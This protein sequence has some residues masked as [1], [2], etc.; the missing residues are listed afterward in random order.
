[1]V[2]NLFIICNFFAEWFRW[3][4]ACK[5]YISNCDGISNSNQPSQQLD[6]EQ[7]QHQQQQQQQQQQAEAKAKAER[8]NRRQRADDAAVTDNKSSDDHAGSDTR[9]KITANDENNI[10]SDNSARDDA[11]SSVDVAATDNKSSDDHAG[12]DTRVKITANDDDNDR[13][14]QF[15]QR[16]IRHTTCRRKRKVNDILHASHYHSKSTAFSDCGKLDTTR[17]PLKRV[18]GG[19]MPN[20]RQHEP[21]AYQTRFVKEKAELEQQRRP[22]EQQKQAE[23]E[24]NAKAKSETEAKAKAKVKAKEKAAK[25]KKN[26]WKIH[27]AKSMHT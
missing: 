22:L 3:C 4:S 14:Q 25:I 1:M 20:S 19:K 7:Q 16:Y 12:P 10:I 23:A 24:A 18:R 21:E 11:G 6:H 2:P 5:I 9:V 27:P 17:S 15:E 13:N 26:A 8:Q